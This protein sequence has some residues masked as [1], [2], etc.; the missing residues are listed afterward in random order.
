[1]RARDRARLA[2]LI[3]GGVVLAW[4]GG[5]LLSSKNSHCTDGPAVRACSGTFSSDAWHG[6]GFGAVIAGLV[7]ILAAVAMV[8]SA[9]RQGHWR[10]HST[11][12]NE[13]SR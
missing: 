5:F 8:V 4:V 6:V 9:R 3:H 2:A 13:S 12:F 1:M 11:S 10:R 7:L